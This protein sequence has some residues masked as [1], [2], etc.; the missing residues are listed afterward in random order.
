VSGLGEQ[1]RLL[2]AHGYHVFP[3][4]P[5][6]KRPIT[7]NG[8]KDA[9]RDE[10][11]IVAWWQRTPDANIGIACGASGVVVLDIDTKA[12]ADPRVILAE[13]DRAGAPVVGTGLAPERSERY[14]RSL[15]RRR[16]VQAYF[17]GEMPSAARLTIPG[18][19]IKADGGYV[20]APGSVHPCGVEY[21]GQLPPVHELPPVP[22]WLRGLVRR[23]DPARLASGRAGDPSRVLAGLARVVRDAPVG[24]RPHATFG[25]R[26]RVADHAHAGRLDEQEGVQEIRDAAVE[27]GLPEVE[28]EQTIR[29]ALGQRTRT[30]A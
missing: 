12:G 21:V 2:A 26:N 25:A 24:S 16:G 30:A 8:F 14:P 15:P 4:V 28:V 6:A 9:T 1:A 10:R 3:L 20:V 22:D 5:R 29:S 13:F 11:Q 17:R 18:A 19:E 7:S 27:A 23:P